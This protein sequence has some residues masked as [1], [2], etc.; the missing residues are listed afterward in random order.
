MKQNGPGRAGPGLK[1]GGPGRAGPRSVGPSKSV[2]SKKW[3]E[4]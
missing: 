1:S 3:G 4:F 2:Q